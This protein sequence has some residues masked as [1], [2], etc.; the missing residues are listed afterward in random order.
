MVASRN[1]CTQATTGQAPTYYSQG[2][3]SHT[4]PYREP[5]STNEVHPGASG[6]RRASWSWLTCQALVLAGWGELGWASCLTHLLQ[7]LCHGHWTPNT[8]ESSLEGSLEHQRKSTIPTISGSQDETKAKLAG[9]D[10]KQRTEETKLHLG[11]AESGR[12]YGCP[13]HGVNLLRFWDEHLGVPSSPA[14]SNCLTC[15]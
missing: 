4:F 13:G 2:H 12:H 6:F 8:S 7:C 1:I 9:L 11:A 3:H 14:F 15:P 10:G 5:I